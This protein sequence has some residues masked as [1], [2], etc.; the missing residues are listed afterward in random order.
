MQKAARQPDQGPGGR[1]KGERKGGKGRNRKA[2]ESKERE[3][4]VTLGRP[5]QQN[6]GARPVF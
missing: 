5:Q 1:E 3:A 4:P 6:T 2:K